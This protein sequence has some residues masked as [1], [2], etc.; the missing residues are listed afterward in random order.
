[1]SDCKKQDGEMIRIENVSFRYPGS[2][3]Y[4]INDLSC[5]FRRG[6]ITAV[7]GRNGCGKTTLTHLITGVFRPESGRVVICGG[8]GEPDDTT[9]KFTAYPLTRM[10]S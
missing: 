10:V 3:N 4:I 7:T 8:G 6:E 5:S 9:L 2:D 1:M